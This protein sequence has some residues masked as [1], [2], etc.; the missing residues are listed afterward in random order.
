MQLHRPESAQAPARARMRR[1]AVPRRRGR[2]RPPY[3]YPQIWLAGKGLEGGTGHLG[4]SRGPTQ[5]K[6][7]SGEN[8]RMSLETYGR[9]RG[10]HKSGRKSDNEQN[11]C[12]ETRGGTSTGEVRWRPFPPPYG[13]MAPHF[14][15]VSSH[16]PPLEFF[17]LKPTY[18]ASRVPGPRA[19]FNFPL[20]SWPEKLYSFVRRWSAD[21]PVRA[22][23]STAHRLTGCSPSVRLHL[24]R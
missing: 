23:V 22:A 20:L 2:W 12:R 17:A 14:L 4:V 21:D 7:G 16:P 11:W 8:R 15:L 5:G 10:G 19:F 13:Q 6:A 18:H 1:P 24:G 3:E 9:V